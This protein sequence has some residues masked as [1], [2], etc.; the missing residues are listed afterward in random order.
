MERQSLGEWRRDN[1]E[2]EV[3]MIGRVG[4][5][6]CENH[7]VT[8]HSVLNMRTEYLVSLAKVL[9]YTRLP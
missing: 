4:Q 2:L 3:C 8:K 6:A 1:S 9:M 5:G 7:M